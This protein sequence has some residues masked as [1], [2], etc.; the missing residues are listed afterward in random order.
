MEDNIKYDCRWSED[1]DEKFID[2]FN[3]VQDQVFQ[4]EHSRETF[5]HQYIENPYG[6]SVIVV[7]YLN[8]KPVAARS[9]WRN[10]I[11][12]RES[13]QPGRT[14]VLEACRGKGIFREM[15]LKAIAMLPQ[16]AIIYN[17]PNQNSYPG[18]IKMGWRLLHDYNLRLMISTK[19]F[20]AEHPHNM[21]DA[22]ARWW[23]VGK[24][25]IYHIRRGGHYFLVRHDHRPMLGKIVA[26]VSGDIAKEFPKSHRRIFFYKSEKQS[27]YSK[28]FMK[29]HVVCRNTDIDY[30]PTWKIDAI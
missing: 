25:G 12:E 22:Y 20:F 17:F 8:D 18:Y 15:T 23:V 21:D 11:G 2:D 6:S 19:D 14:C 1:C 30:I 29:S 7:V 10:D 5:R 16:D 27:F 3:H 28:Y 24:A 13:Y 9:L 4:G 26:C